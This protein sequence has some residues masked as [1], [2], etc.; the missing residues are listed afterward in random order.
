MS[1]SEYTKEDIRK[2]VTTDDWWA[3]RAIE[4]LYARQTEDEQSS[5]V[6]SHKN[7]VGFNGLDAPFLTSMA[8]QILQWR[9]QKKA[10]TNKYAMPLSSRQ[11]EASKKLL[12][13]YSGQLLVISQ[14]REAMEK[15]KATRA[16]KPKPADVPGQKYFRITYPESRRVSIDE[17]WQWVNDALANGEIEGPDSLPIEDL[18]EQMEQEGKITLVYRK[19]S[20]PRFNPEASAAE[21]KAWDGKP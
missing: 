17:A 3:I 13:K 4:A 14:A 21:R 9:K 7:S 19:K 2:M 20:T 5:E 6:T 10:G 12:G 16:P 15:A 18:M 1:S 11:L 8:K